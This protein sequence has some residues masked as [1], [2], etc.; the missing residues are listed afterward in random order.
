M[1]THR[2]KSNSRYQLFII[3]AAGSLTTMAGGVVA[4]I[5]PDIIEQLKLD[6]VLA[7][8]LVSMHCFT[9]AL[10][11]PFLGL[12]A[13]KITPIRVLVPC[14]M[15][16]GVVG[17]SGAFMP[18]IWTLL[19]TRALLGAASGGIAAASLGLLSQMYEGEARS[20]AIGYATAALTI[21]GIA[22]PLVGGILGLLDWR[23]CFYLYGIAII[24]GLSAAFT[25]NQHLHQNK[26]HKG[27]GITEGLSKIA[28]E[29]AFWRLLITI[30]MT[31]MVMYAMLIYMPIYLKQT[32][33]SNAVLIGIVLALKALGSSFVAAFVSQRFTKKLGFARSIALGLGIMASVAAIIPNLSNFG[34]ILV[35]AICFGLGFGLTLPNLYANL[36]QIAPEQLRSSV[37]AAGTGAGFLGQFT[38]PV[39]LGPILGWGGL[40]SVFYG[41]ALI[42][43]IASIFAFFANK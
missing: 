43:V 28:T 2:T 20:Q 33:N 34:L 39:I 42:A 5:L 7:G 3:L 12:L 21:T 30:A 6:P 23:Y 19:M 37:L 22:Y 1:N 41:T 16:Y 26:S 36:A 24:L 31:S 14:L 27:L 40:D 32:F 4:P 10:F 15:F 38:S 11:S 29:S 9:I 18:D 8:N 35:C 13:D 17:V 25:F